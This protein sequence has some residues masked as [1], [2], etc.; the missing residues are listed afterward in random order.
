MASTTEFSPETK[1]V[2]S[3]VSMT[4]G[5]IAIP[6]WPIIVLA[7]FPLGYF[8]WS[9]TAK[10]LLNPISAFKA[11]MDVAYVLLLN[12]IESMET[13]SGQIWERKTRNVSPQFIELSRKLFLFSARLDLKF[14]N[15]LRSEGITIDTDLED[16][17][18]KYDLMPEE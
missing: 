14:L 15:G 8:T 9:R 1:N 7:L 18:K 13:R 16:V 3:I 2:L 17:M 5:V 4:I 12:E 6:F 10:R 11:Y